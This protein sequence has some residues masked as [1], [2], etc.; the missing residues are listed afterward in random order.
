MPDNGTYL[1]TNVGFSHDEKPI[2]SLQTHDDF[3]DLYPLGNSFTLTFNTTH[4]YCIGWR[5]ITLGEQ[6]SCP[7]KQ[8]VD[9]KY[10]Q[11][12]A[13]QKR[14][15]FNPAFYHASSVSPQQEARNQESHILY[16]AHFGH[17]VVKVGISHAKR[18]NRRLLEQGARSAI[19]LEELSS[20]HIA[21]HYESQIANLPGISETIQLR[22]KIELL[23]HPYDIASAKNELIT[24]KTT[25]EAALDVTFNDSKLLALD[26]VYFPKVSHDITSAHN[27]A[28]QQKISGQCIGQLG[29]LLFCSQ[30]DSLL[31]LPLKKFVGYN[32]T[33]RDTITPIS[34]P[35]KQISLF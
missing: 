33:M 8:Q 22:K 23:A 3:V 27:L 2:L 9:A 32:V 5:D 12:S 17:G 6:H 20:A 13:C 4:R 14:T 16:L 25:I 19:I 11:C 1:L 30:N 21:R 15:G 10:E 31:Y 29:S 7:D 26:D 28:T 18:G 35:A 34:T 24:T